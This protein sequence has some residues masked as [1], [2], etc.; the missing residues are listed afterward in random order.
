[1]CL[2]AGGS[3]ARERAGEGA[4]ERGAA[5]GKAGAGRRTVVRVVGADG[6]KGHDERLRLG[7]AAGARR[8]RAGECRGGAARGVGREG[9]RAPP[10]RR[11]SALE[12]PWPCATST[13]APPPAACGAPLGLA[14]EPNKVRPALGPHEGVLG[15]PRLVDL[16]RAA[17]GGGGGWSERRRVHLEGA[18][19]R[20][21][22]QGGGA[23]RAPPTGFARSVRG[24]SRGF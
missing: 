21:S 16:P 4:P 1:M 13:P 24:G 6:G 17:W 10:S 7:C 19:A 14:C 11:R 5:A 18:G 15:A 23:A 20:A 8:E 3:P 12:G 22:Q 2:G 9:V